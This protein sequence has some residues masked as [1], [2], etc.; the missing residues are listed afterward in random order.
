MEILPLD[1]DDDR[2]MND[3][4]LVE[5]AANQHVRP[6]WAP[7]GLD[8]WILGW[9]ADD[10]WRNH[11]VGAWD[12]D[13]L[14]GF[15]AG[16]NAADT[17]DTTW[18]FVWVSPKNH[19]AGIGA[20]LVR[21]AEDA[22]QECTTRFTASAYRPSTGEIESLTRH[23]SQPLGY[24]LATTVTV[25]ELDLRAAHLPSPR[26]VDGYDISTHVNGV[27]EQ[28]QGQVGQIK[29]L[30]DAEAPHGDLAWAET[31]VSPAEYAG[32]IELWVAQGRT[33]F[34]SIAVDPSG[35]VVAWTCLVAAADDARPAEIQGTLVVAEHRG[36]GL[37]AAVKL[38]CLSHARHRNNVL[39]VRTSSD[40][41]NV[42]MRTINTE[43]GFLPVE[44]EII[45][46]KDRAVE[47]SPLRSESELA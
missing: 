36:H 16:M 34:E 4:Y 7:L 41:A 2:A 10:G 30:V 47:S 29:G 45:I 6:G 17:P 11:L 25:V 26:V 22:S 9:R 21:A 14:L 5:C 3:A 31:P 1:V 44:T 12:G 27:P 28:F 18:V 39:R 19:R 32:E 13:E 20:A 42:W 38:A 35:K 23:F 24:V 8:A 33:V 37:G 15:A 43:L 46:R 40:D